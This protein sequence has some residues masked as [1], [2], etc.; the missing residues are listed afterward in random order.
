MGEACAGGRHL[1]VNFNFADLFEYAHWIMSLDYSIIC[2][3]S[4]LLMSFFHA[5]FVLIMGF[6]STCQFMSSIIF[7][8]ESDDQFISMNFVS[9]R[10]YRY[11]RAGK[12]GEDL[13]Y[14]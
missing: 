11:I 3:R 7:G 10:K 8:N 12:R 13:D 6:I 4:L 1:A 5:I 9:V 2:L 14:I